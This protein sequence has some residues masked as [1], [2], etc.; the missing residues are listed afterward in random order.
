MGELIDAFTVAG[1][2]AFSFQA[3][4]FALMAIGLN[5]HFGYTGLLN[6]GQIAFA[7]P[8]V[9]NPVYTA[10]VAS[11]QEVARAQGLRLMLHSTGADA[12]DELAMVRDLKHRFVDGL[13]LASSGL[14]PTED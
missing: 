11:I 13:I 2:A 12:E 5:V 6:F 7:M 14:I 1:K 4:F 3:I 8:D 9:G 10:M